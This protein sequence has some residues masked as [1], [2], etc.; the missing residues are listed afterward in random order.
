MQIRFR[1]KPISF[2]EPNFIRFWPFLFWEE[3]IV[4]LKL[5]SF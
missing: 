4:I 3:I 2:S 5:S 1:K